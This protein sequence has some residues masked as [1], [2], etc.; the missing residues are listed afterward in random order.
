MCKIVH[1]KFEIIKIVRNFA[2]GSSLKPC[3][4][5]PQQQQQ[6]PPRGT[7]AAATRA[8]ACSI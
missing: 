7:E 4:M 8:G 6:K 1:L 5:Q 2:L 3:K